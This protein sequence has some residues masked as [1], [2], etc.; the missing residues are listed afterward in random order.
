MKKEISRASEHS[1][2]HEA[3]QEECPLCL[4]INSPNKIDPLYKKIFPEATANA[5]F[6]L[7]SVDLV[8]RPDYGPITQDH[9]IIF[10][11][12]HF[13]SFATM[14]NSHV[15]QLTHMASIAKQQINAKEYFMFEHG[16]GVYKDE[17]TACGNSIYHAHLHI[18]PIRSQTSP[19]LI[20]KAHKK[21]KMEGDFQILTINFPT[22]GALIP[23]L[24]ECT[25]NN[26][27]LMMKQGSRG[28]V[29]VENGIKQVP[30]Q[31]LRKVGA[32][33]LEGKEAFWDWKTMT[34]DDE[35]LIRGRILNTY[36]QWH[37]RKI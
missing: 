11:K 3:I 33:H 14:A 15:E 16:A 8:M 26:P 9:F 2:N 23:I 18:L 36:N 31:F 24:K 6:I 12:K 10:P 5:P 19:S 21:A 35:K 20:D 13:I 7:E 34:S 22:D 37:T 27:Y 25:K 4:N 32:Q 28:I 1:N 30:S 29:F 17:K